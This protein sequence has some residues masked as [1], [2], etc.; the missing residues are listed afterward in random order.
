VLLSCECSENNQNKGGDVGAAGARQAMHDYADGGGRVI[1][2]H[3][4]YT[5][6]KNSP[7]S[8]FQEIAN[9]GTAGGGGSG[10]YDVDTTF[11]RGASFSDWLGNVNASTSPGQI[12]LSDVTDSLTSVNAPAQ[13]WIKKNNAVRYFSFAT[14]ISAPAQC[15][16]VAFTDLHA[17]GI[18]SGGST[19]PNGCPAPG[20][21]NAQQKALEFLLFDLAACE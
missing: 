19:F 18:S 2:T 7:Q 12:Q 4:H 16:R 6:L 9:W 3:Y 1:A 14:P 5:W 10:T 20:G 11:A 21:L 17:M 8:D 13:S 15:G